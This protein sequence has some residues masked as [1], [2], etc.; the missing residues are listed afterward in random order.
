VKPT[1]EM[2]R[3]PS[4]VLQRVVHAGSKVRPGA[5]NAEVFAAA[6][7][8]CWTV[9]AMAQAQSLGAAP[10]FSPASRTNLSYLKEGMAF[11]LEPSRGSPA[12]RIR[13]ENYH[14][15]LPMASIF[16]RPIRSTSGG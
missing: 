13:L 10:Y 12:L 16:T 14:I 11:N 3:S 7:P 4:E 8:Y 2:A 6:D 9:W 15:S 1:A 5:T